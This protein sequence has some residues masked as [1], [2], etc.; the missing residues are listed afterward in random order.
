MGWDIDKVL[1]VFGMPAADIVKQDREFEVNYGPESTVGTDKFEDKD[2]RLP[3]SKMRLL[4]NLDNS[5]AN[6]ITFRGE[7]L[8]K[9]PLYT[10]DIEH[11]LK[12]LK[13]GGDYSNVFGKK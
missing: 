1:K 5:Y 3:L 12:S 7:A 9:I 2:G 10:M 6:Q 8:W 4:L 13:D 11:G